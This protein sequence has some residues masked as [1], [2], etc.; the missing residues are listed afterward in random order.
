[1]FIFTY[2]FYCSNSQ[3]TL[4]LQPLLLQLE[5]TTGEFYFCCFFNNCSHTTVPLHSLH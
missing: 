3:T 2:L 4:P 1:M 5:V